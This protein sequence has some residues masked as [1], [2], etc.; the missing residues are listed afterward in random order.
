MGPSARPHGVPGHEYVTVAIKVKRG[1]SPLLPKH[2]FIY[3]VI[4]L[5]IHL[6]L[7]ALGLRCSSGPF[8]GFREP[9]LLWLRCTG[10]SPP[11]LLSVLGTGSRAR[12]L[13]R[14]SSWAPEHRLSSCGAQLLWD[15]WDLPRL[16]IKPVSPALAGGFFTTEPPGKPSETFIFN[17]A[18]SS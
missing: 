12:G 4:Y 2:K 18:D 17:M 13:S 8:S 1:K 14:G 3:N 7:A 15:M 5:F 9:G 16:G 10:F 6:F 11:W